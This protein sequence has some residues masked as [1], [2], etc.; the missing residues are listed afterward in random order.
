MIVLKWKSIHVTPL[1]RNYQQLPITF[2]VKVKGF[3]VAY[4]GL[5]ILH[6][7][8]PHFFWSSQ[9]DLSLF[10]T[11]ARHTL[12]PRLL[13]LLLALPIISLPQVPTWLV[14]SLPSGHTQVLSSHWV[15]PWW[16]MLPN[17]TTPSPQ[18]S[19]SAF[20]HYFSLWHISL[21]NL[22]YLLSIFPTKM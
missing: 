14:S 20:L 6:I 10:L 8:C 22:C 13:H 9:T 7:F 5:H 2:W 16:N 4:K 3:T 15:F 19:L 1:F 18:H 11:H 21:T 12:A 17:S